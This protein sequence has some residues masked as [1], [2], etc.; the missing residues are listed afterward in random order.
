MSDTLMLNADCQPVSWLPLSLL[1]WQ[2]AIRDMVL[3]KVDVLEW[4]DDW[5][6]RSAY[7]ETR[8]PAVVRLK[9]Y[10]KGKHAVRYSKAN[11]FL[12][13]AW[14]CQYCGEGLNR[15]TAT[16]D[17]VHPV[18]KG[19]KSVWENAT[20]SCG[21]CNAAKSDSRK[22]KKPFRLPYKPDYYELV[23][24]RKQLAVDY[25]HPT[26]KNYLV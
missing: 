6:V 19:G 5:T 7:W 17:H 21:P 4:Y 14:T 23:N 11:V 8:V 15:K 1:T 22:W 2:E 3:D 20:T 24:K 26:W 16:L 9:S 10:M 13:D 12:R 18:S 25:K